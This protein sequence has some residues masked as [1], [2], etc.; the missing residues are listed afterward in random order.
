MAEIKINKSEMNFLDRICSNCYEKVD[1]WNYTQNQKAWYGIK[2]LL[3]LICALIL[4]FLFPN[5]IYIPTADAAIVLMVM[6]VPLTYHY[7]HM[8][9]KSHIF[10]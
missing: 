3:K 2:N 10:P 6:D 1:G 5:I 7:A 8:D 9:V 4:F